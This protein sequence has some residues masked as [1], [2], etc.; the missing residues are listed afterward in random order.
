[1]GEEGRDAQAHLVKYS[2]VIDGESGWSITQPQ[3]LHLSLAF[4]Y[5]VDNIKTFI[6]NLKI[7]GKWIPFA[8][9]E[10]SS[11]WLWDIVF[12]GSIMQK[13]RS[14][15]DSGGFRAAVEGGQLWALQAQVTDGQSAQG[16]HNDRERQ[17]LSK[18]TKSQHIKNIFCAKL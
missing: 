15:A 11:D 9:P 18:Y 4:F 13:I 16:C 6:S 14:S 7:S 17:A 2:D 8:F 5:C 12:C 1:M 10:L 3:A